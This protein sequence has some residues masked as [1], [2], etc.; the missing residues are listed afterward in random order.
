MEAIPT[1]DTAAMS[2]GEVALPEDLGQ[3]QLSLPS[4]PVQ[5]VNRWEWILFG[6]GLVLLL[7]SC[8][9]RSI[10]LGL[11]AIAL[12]VVISLRRAL[13]DWGTFLWRVWRSGQLDTL[14]PW[15]GLSFA[16]IGG[17]VLSGVADR[18]GIWFSQLNW[19]AVGALGEVLGAGGQIL[20]AILAA[21]IAWRQYII[22]RDLTLQQNLI[23]QQQT[24]DTYF[25]GVASLVV[26]EDGQLDD[27]PLE[28]AILEGRTAAIMN[29]VD[30]F[31]K[32]KILRFLSGAN[33]LSPLRRDSHLGRPIL[34]GRGGYQQDR[35]HGIRV[36][37]LGTTLERA[38]LH[39]T[40]LRGIDFSE[41]SLEETNLAGCD[42]SYANLVGSN[43]RG[44]NLQG[45]DLYGAKFFEGSV[46][47]VTPTQPRRIPN[48]I[49]G[50][51]TGA[52]IE[53]ANLRGVQRLSPEQRYYLCA[54][55]GHKAR[56]TV[57]GGCAGIPDRA[58]EVV[59]QIRSV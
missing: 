3:L 44:A 29:G 36:V 27:W 39:R 8:V 12:L 51:Y 52:L 45:A 1:P 57:P 28:R 5:R 49:T 7:I 32:A 19:D 13:K 4:R 37:H 34:D 26:A 25:D 17:L 43:L 14:L 2:R 35:E 11:P 23:T 33:L 48:Y 18:W 10:G 53:A 54:W 47:A 41:V 50:A 40:E 24:I 58:A 16:G 9:L 38:D 46:E 59:R 42:L 15:V 55:G 30:R 6:L 56:S 22:S 21:Y 31:G 20:I